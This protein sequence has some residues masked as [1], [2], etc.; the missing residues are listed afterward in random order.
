MPNTSYKLFCAYGLLL[1][2]TCLWQANSSPPVF[3]PTG[4]LPGVPQVAM[5]TLCPLC[6]SM[7]AL[8]ILD[9]TAIVALNVY[10]PPRL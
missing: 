8:V 5:G 9:L 1:I 6:F 7:T 4:S 3:P 10:L 2:S